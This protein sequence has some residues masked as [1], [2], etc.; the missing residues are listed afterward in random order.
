MGL[1]FLIDDDSRSD[2]TRPARIEAHVHDNLFFENR[3]W[4]VDVAQR[5]SPNT[6]LTGFEF[7]GTFERN[8][9]CGNGLNEAIFDFR[10]VTTTLGGGAQKFRFGRGSSY[11]SMPRTTR[12]RG[13]ATIWTIRPTIRPA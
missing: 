2:T 8:R 12:W 1:S 6:R 7:E 10:Q 3:N 9:Y 11:S 5:V 13:S 4:G